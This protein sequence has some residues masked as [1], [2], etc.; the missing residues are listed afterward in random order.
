MVILSHYTAAV[1]ESIIDAISSQQGLLA[2]T[3]H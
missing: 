3:F 1:P 2:D